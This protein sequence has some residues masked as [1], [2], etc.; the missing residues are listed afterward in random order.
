MTMLRSDVQGSVLQQLGLLVDVLALSDQHSAEVEIAEF[1]STPHVIECLLAGITLT[2]VE[3]ES[4]LGCAD[5]AQDVVISLPLKQGIA[6][7]GVAVVGR[8]VQGSPLAVILGV[9]RGA[10]LQEQADSLQTALLA[11]K[12]KRGALQVIL[13]L[14]LS[15]ID[16]Q[17]LHEL[18]MVVHSRQM[19]RRPLLIRVTV[20]FRAIFNEQASGFVIA[21]IGS[22]VEGRPP[23]RVDIVDIGVAVLD[24][25]LERLR[26]VLLFRAQNGLVN[27]CF[28]E[29]RHAMVDLVTT[30]H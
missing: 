16:Q 26:F 21:D 3:G 14:H 8:V 1:A 13:P 15:L 19:Q 6:D 22:V 5:L 27:R 30:V 18:H 10:R 7:S 12:V 25:C 17:G 20:H 24:Y 11:C 9:N 23:V 4:V 29:N 2:E 28:A